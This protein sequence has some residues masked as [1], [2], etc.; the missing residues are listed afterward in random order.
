MGLKQPLEEYSREDKDYWNAITPSLVLKSMFKCAIELYSFDKNKYDDV[1]DTDVACGELHFI[2]LDNRLYNYNFDEVDYGDFEDKFG[3]SEKDLMM[4]L[5]DKWAWVD[6]PVLSDDC[7]GYAFVK[8]TDLDC[9]C[10]GG[11]ED[12]VL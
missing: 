9:Y 1:F 12:I 7:E 11:D 10:V 6:C 4:L 8:F 5:S 3:V 2:G